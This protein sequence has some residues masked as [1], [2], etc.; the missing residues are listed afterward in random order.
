M[1]FSDSIPVQFWLTGVETFNEKMICGLAKQDCFC[2]PF[3][4]EDEIIIQFQD[5][6]GQVFYLGVYNENDTSIDEALFDEIA[7]GVYQ[8]NY[9]SGQCADILWGSELYLMGDT[10]I[11]FDSVEC[12][13]SSPPVDTCDIKIRFKIYI[14]DDDIL[15]QSDCIDLRTEH[16]CTKLITYTNSVDFDGI[17]YETGSPV[18]Y[19]YLRVP[20]MFYQEDN[21]Q[22]EEDM[23]LANGEIVTT[24]QKL[25]KKR[26]FEIDYVPNYMHK[27]IQKVLMHESVTI[28][29][30]QWKK[31]DAYESE[32]VKKYNLKTASVLL[33]KYD[34]II[35]N[36][37]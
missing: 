20:A 7:P 11:T 15:A 22:T 30:T 21:P 3:E 13:E 16:P 27:K 9:T 4:C 26:V 28:D 33:T 10:V 19:F 17:V 37:I 29:G 14:T 1:I 12:G 18:P 2:Q 8:I 36:L 34:S 32:P 35:R 6:P 5:D 23:E 31:R 25:Q 24:I